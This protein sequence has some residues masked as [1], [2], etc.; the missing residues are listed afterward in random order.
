MI[1][2]RCL[3]QTSIHMHITFVDL[4]LHLLI[5]F[6]ALVYVYIDISFPLFLFH[7][8]QANICNTVFGELTVSGS[9]R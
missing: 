2:W 7:L 9:V 8:S 3:D 1:C 6:I 5:P 4:S